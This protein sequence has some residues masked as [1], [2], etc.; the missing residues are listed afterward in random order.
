MLAHFCTKVNIRTRVN[1]TKFG[2][3]AFILKADSD[4]YGAKVLYTKLND[5][6]IIICLRKSE[7][8][9]EGISV[10]NF[11]EKLREHYILLYQ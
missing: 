8:S 9:V 3:V 4:M 2:I 7:I 10:C 1:C 5:L 11:I 6:R